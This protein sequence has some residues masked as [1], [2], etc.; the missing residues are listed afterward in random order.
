MN[1]VILTDEHEMFFGLFKIAATWDCLFILEFHC[2]DLFG[3]NQITRLTT[4]QQTDLSLAAR[5]DIFIEAVEKGYDP[6]L[7]ETTLQ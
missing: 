5:R 1:E 6:D 3:H 2:L 7:R 4:A